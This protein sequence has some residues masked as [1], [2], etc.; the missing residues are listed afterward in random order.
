MKFTVATPSFGQLEWLRLC[1]ASVADQVEFDGVDVEHIIQDAGTP[2][3]EEV[4][5]EHGAEFH[6]HNH[7]VFPE[8][9][10]RHPSPFS[11]TRSYSLKIF[12]EQDTGMYDAINKAWRRASGNIVSY[13]NSDEQYLPGTLAKVGRFFDDNK[14]AEM[15]F[16]D[17]LL[18]D[19]QGTPVS[20]RRPVKPKRLHTRVVHLGTM[21]C[22]M[23]FRRSILDRG[24][25]FEPQYRSIGDAEWV[26]RLL[27]A[28]LC[29]RMIREPLAAFTITGENLGGNASALDEATRWAA[30][31][32]TWQR[33]LR[34]FLRLAHWLSK[35]FAGAYGRRTVD[36]ALYTP[37]S[38]SKRM[39]HH[40]R[41]I[42]HRW[43]G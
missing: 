31:A 28:G 38:P 12:S 20:Y 25:F 19:L 18:L 41:S 23:F 10:A 36:T 37:E 34:P 24:F 16:G 7:L 40:G 26:W 29:I 33:T 14:G 9:P 8:E 1:I 42:G 5:R 39:Q 27:G 3:I 22:T 35:A 17:A 43:P 21:S 11:G 6:R 32:P 30:T 4:A 15:C 13:L 2:G